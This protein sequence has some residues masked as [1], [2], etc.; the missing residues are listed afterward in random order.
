MLIFI[1]RFIHAMN[2]ISI[3]K[4]IARP[5]SLAIKSFNKTR[6]PFSGSSII[7]IAL[8]AKWTKK[9]TTARTC[10]E[11]KAK[12]LGF[13]FITTSSSEIR[14]KLF[15]SGF[16][17]GASTTGADSSFG[18]LAASLNSSDIGSPITQPAGVSHEPCGGKGYY[19]Y[20]F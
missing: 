17:A 18:A 4:P 2:S 5:K 7:S 15:F 1:Q 9:T 14:S 19:Y 12:T 6:I 11:K 10:I 16:S 3:G 20:S 13:D 8:N